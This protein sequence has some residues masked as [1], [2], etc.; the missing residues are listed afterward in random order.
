ME[1]FRLIRIAD[2]ISLH[3]KSVVEIGIGNFPY[4][5]LLLKKRGLNVSV[6]DIKY[7]DYKGL[8]FIIDDLLKPDLNL[9]KGKQLLY[10]IRPPVEFVIYLKKL[11]RDV[12]SDL[13]IKPLSSDI[14]DGYLVNYDG[15]YFYLWKR[16]EI[17]VNGKNL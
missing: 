13:I 9:Y 8:T 17:K 4:I 2:Y 7:Y 10:S 15:F 11:A 5:A 3:Y 1:R 12:N 16:D 6:T 14:L